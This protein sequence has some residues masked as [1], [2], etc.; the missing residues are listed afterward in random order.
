MNRENE[1]TEIE[2]R[3][4]EEPQLRRSDRE[5]RRG[6]LFTR[7]ANLALTASMEEPEPE[8]LMGALKIAERVQW[9]MAWESGLRSLAE[10]NTWWV[11]PLPSDRTAVGSGWIF[12]KK[13]DGRYKAR[14]VTKGC[15]QEAGI[16]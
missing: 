13:G 3:D 16:D 6:N 11:E 7:Q 5:R 2:E 1:S 15:S 4:A 12:K 14:L 9:K 8:T 10:N